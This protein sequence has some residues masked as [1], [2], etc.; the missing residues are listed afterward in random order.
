[1]TNKRCLLA[2]SLILLLSLF[3]STIP[4]PVNATPE[5]AEWSTVNIPTDGK[6][7]N[8][9]LADGSDIQ[10]LVM[11]ID[12]TIYAGANPSGTSYTL[13]KSTDDGFSWEYTGKVTDDIVDIATSP[14]DADTIYYATL[15]SVYKSTDA[16][17]SF[18]PLAANP[19]GAGSD[20][21]EITAIDVFP[22]DN[23]HIIAAG[24]RDTDNFEY[25]G[26]YILD[27]N[28][29]FASWIDT[30]LGSYDVYAVAFSP[31][32]ASD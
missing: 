10:H 22:L 15:S 28:Q 8:W 14:D 24:T 9:V 20:N 7:G 16:G 19:G 3:V 21:I 18:T 6:S 12:G 31:N 25:G 1:M 11:A 2:L 5:V 17:D 27:E 30:D 29:P 32:F 23:K 13:F 4:T 26:V